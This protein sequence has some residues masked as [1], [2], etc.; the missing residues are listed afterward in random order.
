MNNIRC[1]T[2]LGIVMLGAVAAQGDEAA[3]F[4]I[5]KQ[6][7]ADVVTVSKEQGITVFDVSSS[8]GIGW[9]KI[10]NNKSWPMKA[11]V[12]IT[13][14]SGHPW[15]RMEQFA[16]SKG[17]SVIST[18]LTDRSNEAEDLRTVRKPGS[19]TAKE[20]VP[21]TIERVGD[22]VEVELPMPWLADESQFMIR[23]V[24]VFR[25]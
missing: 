19:A 20:Q 22:A 17:N 3:D 16:V 12:R 11:K 1:P 14:S 5:A 4:T 6:R 7:S 25:N 21:L 23:W 15:K 18:Y 10:Q 2:I 13:Y 9:A 24:D 8:N